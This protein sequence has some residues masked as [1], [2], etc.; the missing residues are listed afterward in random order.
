MPRGG[1]PLGEPNAT[2]S[3]E[4]LIRQCRAGNEVAWAALIEKYQRLV[5]SL[6][7][8]FHLPPEDAADVFQSVWADLHRDLPRLEQANAVR[9][10][11]MTAATR[12]CLLQ[13][14]RR[15]KMQM[16]SGVEAEIP[17]PALDIATLQCEALREQQVREAIAALPE[18]CRK[19]VEWLFFQQPPKPYSEVAGRLG[20][21]E[22]SIGFIR[23]RCLNRLKIL[24]REKGV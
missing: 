13:K 14:K 1:A 22:G 10:W 11:L 17:D 18:R 16:F 8:K 24:L 15:Q 19:I 23:G 21:A 4:D 6:P 7:A 12:R 2:S 20:L 3:D 9:G 5:Y